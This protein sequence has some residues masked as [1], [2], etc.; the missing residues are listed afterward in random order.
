MTTTL[1]ALVLRWLGYIQP[2]HLPTSELMKFVMFFNFSIAGMNVSLMWNLVGFYQAR[3]KAEY[4][5][6]KLLQVCVLKHLQVI[7]VKGLG[8]SSYGGILSS[9]TYEANEIASSVL[10][11]ITNQSKK[12]KGNFNQVNLDKDKGIGE[13]ST[14]STPDGNNDVQVYELS[15]TEG[16]E[17]GLYLFRRV[18]HFRILV[19][20]GDGIAG[21][22]L[23]A[24]KKPNY[25]S[26]PPVAILPDGSGNDL[27]RVLNWGGGLGS[28]E[29]QR[30][31]CMMLQH[32]EHAAV[33]VLYLFNFTEATRDSSFCCW[34]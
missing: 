10:A 14:E 31:L 23:D 33:T 2:S 26:P 1:M 5:S 4:E 3:N 32:M 19:C 8:R 18:P 13:S 17:I 16:P 11:S 9:I 29:G 7:Y 6:L 12:N 24:I 21:W 22:V 25:F 27:A 30:R 15:S 20:G 28:V 34:I